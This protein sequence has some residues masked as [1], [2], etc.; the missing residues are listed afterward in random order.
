VQE[1]KLRFLVRKIILE[2]NASSRQKQDYNNA[3]V[4]GLKAGKNIKDSDTEDVGVDKDNLKSFEK[5]FEFL[6][7]SNERQ[8]NKHPITIEALKK[9]GEFLKNTDDEKA[10]EDIKV[11]LDYKRKIKPGFNEPE[12]SL[13]ETLPKQFKELKP[14]DPWKPYLKKM[15][16]IFYTEFVKKFGED[17]LYKDIFGWMNGLN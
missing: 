16:Q 6:I 11:F 15:Y 17:N 8:G 14:N 10:F 2:A 4:K 12:V 7:N 5:G 9:M 13:K 3:L 1:D